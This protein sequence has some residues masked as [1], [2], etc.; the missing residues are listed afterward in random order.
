MYQQL[1]SVQSGAQKLSRNVELNNSFFKVF[2]LYC[3]VSSMEL[4][5]KFSIK[6]CRKPCQVWTGCQVCKRIKLWTKVEKIRISFVVWK[7]KN[8]RDVDF[9]LHFF[10]CADT[11]FS[12]LLHV[13]SSCDAGFKLR[14]KNLLVP[15]MAKV[16][17]GTLERSMEMIL[18]V[19]TC[20]HNYAK[21]RTL[22]WRV[23]QVAGLWNCSSLRVG[24]I[25]NLP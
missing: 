3:Q 15:F 22:L 17:L 9:Y 14:G 6:F 18:H 12:E 16:E 8:R 7:C 5:V 25:M 21:R 24:T 13:A 4:S 23:F 10:N 19:A 11:G 1:W 2:E 20:E